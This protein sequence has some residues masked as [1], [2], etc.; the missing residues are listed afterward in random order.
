M[1]RGALFRHFCVSKVI[2]IGHA[3]KSGVIFIFFKN[4]QI[5]QI[6]TLWPN[7]TKIASR[8]SCLNRSFLL[9]TKFAFCRQSQAE[10]NFSQGPWR[11][12][13]HALSIARQSFFGWA[14][15]WLV[16]AVFWSGIEKSFDF[17]DRFRNEKWNVRANSVREH[18]H[19]QS[20]LSYC[21]HALSSV[22]KSSL[23][24][25]DLLFV[26][27]VEFSHA[28]KIENFKEG[29]LTEKKQVRSLTLVS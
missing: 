5:K 3:H 10:P 18:Q 1:E 20:P 29:F 14:G 28:W 9:F 6:K 16:S 19:F 4:F 21:A 17:P 2:T 7:M 12:S 11:P 15:G 25:L 24:Q 22:A 23:T 13:R 27:W 8:G 26:P